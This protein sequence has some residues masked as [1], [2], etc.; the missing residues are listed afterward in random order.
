M[1]VC[2][3]KS[4]NVCI[5]VDIKTLNAKVVH[6]IHPIPLVDETLAQLAGARIF[7]KLDAS[8]GFWQILLDTS[9]RHLTTFI[10]HLDTSSSTNS[11]GISSA[12]E[13][14]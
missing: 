13:V 4:G 8:S 7:S 2:Q 3:K 6:D 9:C 10:H 5:C 1:V 14:L 12:P 11:F